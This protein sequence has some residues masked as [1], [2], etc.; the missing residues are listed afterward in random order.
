MLFV[1]RFIYTEVVSA[2]PVNGGSY[3]SLLNTTSKRFAAVAGCMSLLSYVATAVVS[4]ASA[5]YYA[6]S[7][8]ADV[9]VRGTT[10]GILAVFASLA[11]LGVTESA[12]AAALL[13]A[14][15]LC[16]MALLI[17][18]A[19]VWAGAVDGWAT[20]VANV[21]A[22]P[23]P[24]IVNSEG[25]TVSSGTFLGALFFGYC[26]ALLGITGFETTAN[27]VEE[28]RDARVFSGTMRVRGGRAARR[29]R[30]G[31]VAVVVVGAFSLLHSPA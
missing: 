28:L 13:F 12:A 21:S 19:L 27:F 24:A 31:M 5:S 23:L 9:S 6:Q 25:V 11:M 26:S 4:G 8:S 10:L 15:H 16:T 3:T 2:L 7:L 18:W 1:F 30:E 20:L 17:V 29:E 14:F 22:A